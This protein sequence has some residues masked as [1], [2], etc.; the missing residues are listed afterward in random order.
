MRN[1]SDLKYERSWLEID[2][3]AIRENIGAVRRRIDG[4]EQKENL[5]SEQEETRDGKC[6]RRDAALEN[7]HVP[8][9]HTSSE[10]VKIMAVIKADAY[11][12]GAVA[13][14]KALESAVDFFGVAEIDEAEELKGAGVALPILILGYTSPADYTRV[15]EGDIRP[16]IYHVEDARKL[17]ELVCSRRNRQESAGGSEKAWNRKES[18]EGSEKAAGGDACGCR[19]RQNGVGN[20][21]SAKIHIA[22]DTGMTRIGF[23]PTPDSVDAICE[24]ASMEG[25]EIE[26]LFTHFSCADMTDKTYTERQMAVYDKFAADLSEHGVHIPLCHMENSAGIMEFTHHRCRMV[27]S[28]IVTYGLLPSDEVNAG[29]LHLRPAMAWKSRVVDVKTVGAGLGVSYGA[30]Y[31]TKGGERIATISTGYGDGYPRSLSGKGYVL[32][33]GR[34]APILGRVCMDQFMADV[35]GI[36]DVCVEDVVTLVGSDGPETITAEQ[37]GDLSGRFNYEFVCD[38]NKR[39]PRYYRSANQNL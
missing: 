27:R 25:I 14:A 33:R 39:V 35:S 19:M 9:E 20:K 12:H 34:R 1:I 6:E 29:A 22:L 37:I 24:I 7:P 21:K 30:T 23:P 28:G 18:A 10:R 13:V 11:G 31:V 17:S 8:E 32:I 5:R 26:G 3:D 38:I 2:L 16:T 4:T 36:P 15:I